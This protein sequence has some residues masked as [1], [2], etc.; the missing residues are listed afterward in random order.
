MVKELIIFFS[1]FCL[2]AIHNIESQFEYFVSMTYV[3][4]FIWLKLTLL[5]VHRDCSYYAPYKFVFISMMITIINVITIIAIIFII[6]MGPTT[7][8]II[9][10]IITTSS[11]TALIVICFSQ[12]RTIRVYQTYICLLPPYRFYAAPFTF[13]FIICN[14]S[15]KRRTRIVLQKRIVLNKRLLLVSS[16]FKIMFSYNY[17]LRKFVSEAT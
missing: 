1:S 13:I 4:V 15:R 2:Y 7:T 14:L 5:S 8:T 6:L 11:I 16:Y 9:I 10:T 12:R 17:V 3:P